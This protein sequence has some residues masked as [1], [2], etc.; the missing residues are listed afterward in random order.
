[1]KSVILRMIGSAFFANVSKWMSDEQSI[2]GM[3][4]HPLIQRRQENENQSE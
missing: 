4:C 3:V 2:L 1:M